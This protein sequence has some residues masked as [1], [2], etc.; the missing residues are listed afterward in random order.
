VPQL[1]DA[2]TDGV[3]LIGVLH[4]PPLPGSPRKGPSMAAIVDWALRDA[5]ALVQ[6]GARGIIVE[7]LGDAPFSITV[8]PHVTAALAVVARQVVQRFGDR[9]VVGV[10]ALR[11]D[12][13]AALGAAS[14]SGA[15]FV[16]I[17]VHVG[18][19]VTDQGVIEGRARETLL[20][21]QRVAPNTA[22]VADLLVKHAAPLAPV[23]LPQLARDTFHRGGADVLVLTGTG[24]GQPTDLDRVRA[25]RA[26]VP[27]ARVWVGSGVTADT[28]AAVGAVAHGAIVGTCLH[29]DGDLAAPLSAERVRA[30][31]AALASGAS[32]SGLRG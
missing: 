27:E 28:A 5:E 31:V 14:A 13:M 8:E 7:N 23:D 32:E 11:N 25:V 24:T 26:A 21:R 16:R 18:T 29:E 15:G 12:P 1:F 6:G 10:N 2:L 22:V 9:V 4:L 19:M 20:Y 17:N 30:V 3:P